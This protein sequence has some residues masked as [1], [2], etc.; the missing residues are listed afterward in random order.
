M[1]KFGDEDT[2]ALLA[3]KIGRL[4]NSIQPRKAGRPL[5]DAFQARARATVY[6]REDIALFEQFLQREH[7]AG[8]GMTWTKFWVH[9]IRSTKEYQDWAKAN[10]EDLI[11]RM[12]VQN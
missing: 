10:R 3:A 11:K 7:R 12:E 2:G 8:R 1:I 4:M 6:L 9:A 5:E